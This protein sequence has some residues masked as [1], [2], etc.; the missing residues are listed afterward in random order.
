M[1]STIRLTSALGGLM[2]LGTSAVASAQVAGP[3]V[4]PVSLTASITPGSIEG[5]VR[6]EKGLPIAKATVSAFGAATTFTT[7]DLKGRFELRAL[8]PGRYFVHAHLSGYAAARPLLVEVRG[9]AR[10]ETLIALR[11]ADVA[12]TPI[13]AAGI[14]APVAPMNAEPV[15]AKDGSGPA[16]AQP[17][18][19][20]ADPNETAWRI[21]H[22]RRSI[23][24]ETSYAGGLLATDAPANVLSPLD[25]FG[26]AAGSS[27]RMASNFITETP[28]SGQVNLLTSGSFEGPR[29][30]FS[31]STMSRGIA[32]VSLTAPAG[33]QADWTVRGALT[34]ADIS[35][36]IV[37]G[38]YATRLTAHHQR[39][40]GLSYSTQRYT[41]GNP[42]AL[43]E[44][45]DGSRNVG[46]IYGFETL[47]LTPAIALTYGARYGQYDYLESR[48]LISPRVE[49]AL[50]PGEGVR[51]SGEL[52]RQALAPGAEEFLPPG[53][54]GIWLPPQRTFS[55]LEPGRPMQAEHTLHAAVGVEQSFG[56][57][58]LELRAFHQRVTDQ[59]MTLFGAEIPDQPSAKLGHYF[60]GSAGDAKATGGSATFRTAFS[61]RVRGSVGYTLT[62]A[63]LRPDSDLR[64]IILMAP[65]A[66]RP[67]AQQIH[68]VATSIEA[69]VPETATKILMLYRV[70]NGFAH[71]SQISSGT[72]TKRGLDSRFDLQV[73][74]S[75]PFMDFGTARWEMLLAVRNFF[76]ETSSDQSVYDE[77]LVIR[78]P[79]RIVGGITMLF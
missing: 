61:K 39:G 64:Y 29:E 72:A 43:R 13:L 62:N 67:D 69:K 11:R 32:Y 26:R 1:G 20:I 78:P 22:S 9:S 50:S 42:L 57:S 73:R 27:V 17:T 46:E 47:T 12:S 14:G 24:K 36:W 68:D 74:Q 48:N 3:R 76:R 45:T 18:D 38:S 59:L 65:S 63:R 44:V 16:D 60:V 71:G 19:T 2:L 75:L 55:A 10:A 77:L 6:D 15:A 52:S 23:L 8:P 51:I 70:G 7:T 25:S 54:T 37:A 40:F 53:D 49:L 31:P 33:S 56:R 34:Q 35:S 58:S 5:V 79:K 4:Q 21:N 28:F 66:V 41:G 30:L